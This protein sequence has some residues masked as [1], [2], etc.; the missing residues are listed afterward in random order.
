MIATHGV[1]FRAALDV[2]R[3]VNPLEEIIIGWQE[4]LR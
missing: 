2:W 1:H 3:Y 4:L